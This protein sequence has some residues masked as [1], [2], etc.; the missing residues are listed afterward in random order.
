MKEALAENVQIRYTVFQ[1]STVVPAG[2]D[3]GP[4]ANHVY[5]WPVAY[6]LDGVKEWLFAQKRTK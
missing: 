5:T 6:E 4:G 2:R 1:G 3:A